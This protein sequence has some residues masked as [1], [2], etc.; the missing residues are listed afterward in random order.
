MDLKELLTYVS[1]MANVVL[2]WRVLVGKPAKHEIVDQPLKVAT[3]H[4]PVTKADYDRHVAEVWTVIN[5]IRKDIT[6]SAANIAGIRSAREE[7]GTRLGVIESQLAEMNR[8]MGELAGA[9][10][11]LAK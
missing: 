3:S 2:A 5:G 1:F 10:N 6:D 8:T 11:M 7:N 4:E 9:L